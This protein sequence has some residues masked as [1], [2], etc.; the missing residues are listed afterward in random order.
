MKIVDGVD[1]EEREAC[2]GEEVGAVPRYDYQHYV[3]EDPQTE[4]DPGKVLTM[5]NV[6]NKSVAQL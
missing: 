2:Q 4:G 1:H 5:K 6:C 3:G